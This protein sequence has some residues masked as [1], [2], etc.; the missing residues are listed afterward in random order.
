M[1]RPESPYLAFIVG[2]HVATAAAEQ[3]L[4]W[5]IVPATIP[6]GLSGDA[7]DAASR[8]ATTAAG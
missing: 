2:S 8:R 3:K 5:M 1:S 4:A 7:R 6:V